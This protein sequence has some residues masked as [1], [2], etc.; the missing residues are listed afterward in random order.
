MNRTPFLDLLM[1]AAGVRPRQA[2]PPSN[3]QTPSGSFGQLA[4]AFEQAKQA[5]G[6][7]SQAAP[8]PSTMLNYGPGDQNAARTQYRP[9]PGAA[10]QLLALLSGAS[11]QADP[12][13]VPNNAP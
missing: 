4:A 13:T 1:N 3:P 12:S 8:V 11:P 6:Q 10:D 2:P 9:I 7:S 5:A